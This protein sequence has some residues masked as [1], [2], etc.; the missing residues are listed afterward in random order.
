MDRLDNIKLFFR[1]AEAG[2]FSKAARQLAMAQ[3]TASKQ[4]A[5]LERR[6][7]VQLLQRTTRGLAIT[8]AGQHY[9]DSAIRLIDEL[10][11][12]DEAVS[13]QE[14][15]PA[16]MVRVN[17]PPGFAA[18][19]LLPK[20]MSFTTKYP[21]LEI[22]FTVSQN[23]A[24]LVEER[25]DVAIRMGNLEDS[26]LRFRQVGTATAIV[27]ASADYLEQHGEPTT[28]ADLERHACIASMYLGKPRP[29]L[30]VRGQERVSI[31]PR[32]SIRS[33]DV[34][35][36]KAATKAG[37]GIAYAASWLFREELVSGSVRQLL[38]DYQCSAVPIS[39]VWAGDRILPGR[40]SA[41]IDFVADI[42]AIEPALR[43]Q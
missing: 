9:Y 3:S 4:I 8:A 2:S 1:V 23:L 41:F 7:G 20:L 36:T 15:S 24:N 5:E 19:Y 6:L 12:L 38:T 34:E 16:G 29:W 21:K 25:I 40:T 28:P 11:S 17:S 10:E 31:E 26:D 35:L 22:D 33:D 43:P 32:G 37:L 18:S 30:F 14:R 27:V 39:A 42:C 13:E